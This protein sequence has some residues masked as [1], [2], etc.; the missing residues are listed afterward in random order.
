MKQLALKECETI[1]EMYKQSSTQEASFKLR[2][3]S[4]V[5]RAM[6]MVNM[7]VDYKIQDNKPTK[8]EGE[9]AKRNNENSVND[10]GLVITGG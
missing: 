10:K 6:Q 7:I 1:N 3:K 2:P 4:S 9:K 5:P 8:P